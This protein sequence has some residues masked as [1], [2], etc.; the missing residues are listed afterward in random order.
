MEPAQKRKR[1]GQPKPAEER[2]RNNLTFRARDQLKADL[3]AAA[4]YS[5]RSVS[6]E[7]EYRLQR[8]FVEDAQIADTFGD[9]RTYRVFQICAN[10][11]RVLFNP[12]DTSK[13][14]LDDSR[15]FD[16]VVET[17]NRILGA[18]R[19][20]EV[21]ELSPLA[22]VVLKERPGLLDAILYRVKVGH[23]D[24][25]MVHADLGDLVD[26]LEFEIEPTRPGFGHVRLA[27]SRKQPQV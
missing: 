24:S 12:D 20:R 17:V 4:E 16:S 1:G 22:G 11:T 25:A 19:P 14:W 15:L 10:A 27:G 7:I 3:E 5:G 13:S 18:L 9:R 8:S 21:A 23:P 2:K 6:E 26:R